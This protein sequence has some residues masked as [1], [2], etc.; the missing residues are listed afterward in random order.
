VDGMLW[1]KINQVIRLTECPGSKKTGSSGGRNALVQNKPGHLVNGMPWYKK[2]LSLGGRNALVQKINNT[3]LILQITKNKI[4]HGKSKFRNRSKKSIPI[5]SFTVNLT[6][7][8]VNLF[9]T[10]F[11]LKVDFISQ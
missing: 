9:V 1:F 5:I 3:I 6:K 10:T 8:T 4:L 2:N 11:Y 7:P